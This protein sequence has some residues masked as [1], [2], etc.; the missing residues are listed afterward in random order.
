MSVKLL[1]EKHL[2][3]LS[4]KGGCTGSFQSIHVKLSH[5]WKSRVAA[6]NIHDQDRTTKILHEN[7]LFQD[8]NKL[9]QI[10]QKLLKRYFQNKWPLLF[11]YQTWPL[12]LCI[13]L[14][15]IQK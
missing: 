6:H 10:G 3:F 7:V 12:L 8:K 11:K 9:I 2:K 14:K 4:L 5:C 15:G 1:T 13:N